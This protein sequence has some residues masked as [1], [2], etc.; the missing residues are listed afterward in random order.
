MDQDAKLVITRYKKGILSC[1]L[2]NNRMMQADFSLEDA[3]IVGNVYIAKVINAVPNLNA[4][5]LEYE[6]G[7]KCYLSFQHEKP[8]ILNRD[9]KGNLS[10]GDLI[11]VQI[12]KDAI[13]SKE[14]RATSNISMTGQYCVI[15][16][17]N[18]KIGFSD[19]L[20]K[21]QKEQIRAY[22]PKTHPY[23]IVVRTNTG[24]LLGSGRM[25][26]FTEEMLMLQDRMQDILATAA[27]RTCYSVLYQAPPAYLTNIRD[28]YHYL[29]QQIITD[30]QTLY[31]NIQNYIQKNLPEEIDKLSFY[32]DT[33]YPMS[34]LYSLEHKIAEALSAKVW[35]KSG[36]YLVI[37][38]T[39]ALVAIDVNSGK[40][41]SKKLKDDYILQINK[42]AA[43]EVV[44]QMKLRNL[45]G[46]ILIDFINIP[47]KYEEELLQYLSNLCSRDQVPTRVIDMT[48]LGLVEIT[49]K[50]IR[51]SLWEQY[52][53]IN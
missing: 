47:K 5:F 34:K 50:K 39:E 38:P 10:S 29:Y 30:D 26:D 27:Y 9:A 21:E 37:Q 43:K 12:I 2:K 24:E 16:S 33:S 44:W 1:I 35:L 7:K 23:G 49:R 53:E 48:P 51:K 45:S 32:E 36:A 20:T 6:P 3:S 15:T 17:E 14:P 8:T 28:T 4:A 42:E 25:Q 18:K 52:Q 11:A 40:N 13:K 31:D 19:K 22:L 41:D 46:M